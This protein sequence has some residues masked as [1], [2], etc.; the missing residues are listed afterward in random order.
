MLF[1]F[2][3]SL[4]TKAETTT[5]IWSA[6]TLSAPINKDFSWWMETQG[7]FSDDVSRL[8]QLFVQP[9]IG[10]HANESSSVWFGYGRFM[11]MPPY[12]SSTLH[13]NRLW[14]QYLWAKSLMN[15][16]FISRSR[17]E[18]RFIKNFSTGWRI[19]QLLQAE[20]SLTRGGDY[21]LIAND[22]VFY[23]FN[24]FNDNQSH[25]F[26]QNRAYIGLGYRLYE[27][28][29]LGAGY[30]NHW[31]RRATRDNFTGHT[32]LLSLSWS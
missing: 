31:V 26:D 27:H 18:E 4:N 21:L 23:N 5:Q 19:R 29:L 7:W 12:S 6:L 24:D 32:L 13:E 28:Y 30:L 1:L 25:G 14:Q 8:S 16:K 17:L 15:I 10:Y 9:A 2:C 11:I 22:E 3:L 20:K